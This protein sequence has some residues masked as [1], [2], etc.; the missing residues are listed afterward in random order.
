MS[1]IWIDV[2]T[3]VVMPANLLPLMSSVDFRTRIIGL[4]HD[5]PGMNLVYNFVTLDGTVAQTSV[6]P[7][8]SGN[9]EWTH[10]GDGM[11]TVFIPDSGGVS[12]NNDTEGF[13]WFTG[14]ADGVLLWR[15]PIVGFMIEAPDGRE[16]AMLKAIISMLQH[17]VALRRST[18]S[19]VIEIK[20]STDAQFTVYGLG[21]LTDRSALYF[22]AKMM[23][24]KDSVNDNDSIIQIEETKGLLRINKSKPSDHAN[25]SIVVNN[26]LAGQ[27]TISISAIETAKL[28]P[29]EKY[30]YDIKKDNIVVGEGQFLVSTAITRTVT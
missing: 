24:E 30:C 19:G 6:I 8:D 14:I 20:R 29:N 7:T 15:S 3:E 27:I 9:Y 12:I 11:Y 2:N 1:G 5:A 21:S 16:V 4:A 25:A 10:I 26:E 28:T 18:M 22:T 17:N 23:R 13:G